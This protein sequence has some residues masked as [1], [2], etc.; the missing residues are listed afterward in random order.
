MAN[1]L[2]MK[3]PLTLH[4]HDAKPTMG[5]WIAPTSLP[6][7]APGNQSAGLAAAY[8]RLTLAFVIGLYL[9]WAASAPDLLRHF[10]EAVHSWTILF[11]A[12]VAAWRLLRNGVRGFTAQGRSIWPLAQLS[13]PVL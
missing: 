12:P 11:F 4:G 8:C 1:R 13:G 9:P 2:D 3:N 7:E 10:G 6:A 5:P